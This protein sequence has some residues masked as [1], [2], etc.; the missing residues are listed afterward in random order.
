[1][2]D[3]NF[4][5]VPKKDWP[6][7]FTPPIKVFK[8]DKYLV[9]AYEEKNGVIRLSVLNAKKDKKTGTWIDGISWDELQKIKS[10]VGYGDLC[11]VEVY[12]ED[13][14]IVNIAAIR[15]L[16]VLPERPEFAWIKQA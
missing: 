15:H 12:P 9:Q 6:L 7:T 13:E 8:S 10:S 2:S 14:N 4:K 5:D 11:A 3:F 16:F 1:M